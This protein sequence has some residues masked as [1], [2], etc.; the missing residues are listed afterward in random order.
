MSTITEAR[1]Q[2]DLGLRQFMINMYN[3]TAAGLALSGAVAWF[4]YSSGLLYQMAG[5]MLLFAFG[6]RYD[7][8]V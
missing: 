1:E 6:S 3:H 7:P 2:Y 8:L 4:V 5:A